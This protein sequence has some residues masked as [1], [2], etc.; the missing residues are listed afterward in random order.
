MSGCYICKLLADKDYVLPLYM[1]YNFANKR[2][3]KTVNI[4]YVCVDCII[5]RLDLDGTNLYCSICNTKCHRKRLLYTALDTFLGYICYRDDKYTGDKTFIPG[6]DT[7]RTK[8]N[9]LIDKYSET[10]NK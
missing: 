2:I 3:E 6:W 7:Y 5:Q 1:Q 4:G 8:R 9:Y 10:S